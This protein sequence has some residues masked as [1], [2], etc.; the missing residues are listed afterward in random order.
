MTSAPDI[1]LTLLIFQGT[2]N[3]VGFLFPLFLLTLS[4]FPLLH[5]KEEEK[6][7]QSEQHSPTPATA[8]CSTSICH[9]GHGITLPAKGFRGMQDN[10]INPH[11]T[12]L[13]N[14]CNTTFSVTQVFPERWML[15]LI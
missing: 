7:T 11:L 6:N 15:E 9:S 13:L 14:Y 3:L 12:R 1:R 8:I 10:L 4:S 2:G 5:K